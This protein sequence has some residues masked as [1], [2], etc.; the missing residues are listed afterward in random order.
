MWYILFSVQCTSSFIKPCWIVH[1]QWP[2]G[3][4]NSH[5]Q[6]PLLSEASCGA[7]S[8]CLLS[9]KQKH[10]SVQTGHTPGKCVSGSSCHWIPVSLDLFVI[11][12]PCHYIPVCYVFYFIGSPCRLILSDVTGSLK[13]SKP[14][15]NLNTWDPMTFSTIRCYWISQTTLSQSL[16][17]RHG[18]QWHLIQSD[19]TGSLKQP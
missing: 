19:A 11:K 4:W 9:L 15:P 16:T 1:W 7:H 13:H 3:S 6:D 17:L 8:P 5:W 18:I 2:V 12:S 14:V 10:T